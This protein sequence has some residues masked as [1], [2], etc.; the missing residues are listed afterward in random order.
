M[1]WHY[2]H[3]LLAAAYA[4]IFAVHLKRCFPSSG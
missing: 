3:L 1:N 2:E 4:T